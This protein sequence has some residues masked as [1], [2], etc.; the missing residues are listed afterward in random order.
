[1]DDRSNV[2]IFCFVA[3]QPLEK[4]VYRLFF[5]VTDYTGNYIYK[6]G[7]LEFFNH[8][9]GYVEKE[10]DGYKYVYQYKDHLG[11]IRLSYKDADKDGTITTSEIVE[12]KNYYPF[13][14]Q[15]K[16][17]NNTVLS[18][19][20]YG[21]NGKE[22]NDELGLGTLDFGARNYNP[23]LGRWMNIDPLAARYDAYSPYSFTINNPIYFVDPD[24]KQIIIYYNYGGKEREYEYSYKEGRSTK[25]L[26]KFL[27]NALTALDGL[28]EA[29][30]IDTT[31]DGENDTNVLDALIES[32]KE[33][34]IVDSKG[35]SSKFAKGRSQKGRNRQIGTIRFNPNEGVLFDDVNDSTS[36]VLQEQLNSNSLP[37]TAKV[38]SPTSLLGHESLHAWNFLTR[39]QTTTSDGS[40]SNSYRDRQSDKSTQNET[41]AFSN[42]EEKRA[43][44]LSKQI[45]RNL[46]E[47][48]RNNY[49]GIGVPVQGVRSNKIKKDK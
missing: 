15:H 49:R 42:G 10:A 14:L 45:N 1:M 31:G 8:P 46:G 48:P 11:N 9:E 36:D 34:S 33:L 35:K 21:Y 47:N 6:N 39:E 20:P 28:Y 7:Q 24:G 41:P 43:T 22:E 18:E 25:G 40:Y 5:C 44:T 2:L 30:N 37:E 3:R 23:D 4:R 29:S 12:E 19:H 17:Y 13:G 26:P 38:N 16:G 27:A 32:D